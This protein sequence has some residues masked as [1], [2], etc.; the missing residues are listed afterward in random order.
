MIVSLNKTMYT[1]YSF[2]SQ[3][4]GHKRTCILLKQLT[5]ICPLILKNVSLRTHGQHSILAQYTIQN[6]IIKE[7][8]N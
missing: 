4:E 2:H 8:C 6:E 7:V 5:G 1:F 3:V